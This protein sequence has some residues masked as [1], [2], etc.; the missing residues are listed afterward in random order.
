MSLLRLEVEPF[1]HRLAGV[2]RE[3]PEGGQQQQVV[4]LR[5]LGRSSADHGRRGPDRLVG[6]AAEGIAVH[7]A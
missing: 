4:E 1:D 3:V 6:S 7:H 5:A 2:F